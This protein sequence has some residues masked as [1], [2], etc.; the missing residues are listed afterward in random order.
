MEPQIQY[1]K[2]SDGVNIAYTVFGAGDPLVVAPFIPGAAFQFEARIEPWRQWEAALSRRRT[3]IRYDC[4]GSGLSDHGVTDRSLGAM[5][6]DLEAVADSLRL[7]RF[8][9]FGWFFSGPS[10]IAYAA[11]HPARVSHLILWGRRSECCANRTG[12]RIPKPL[13]IRCSA[14]ITPRL[15]DNGLAVFESVSMRTLREVRWFTLLSMTPPRF[16][17]RC[18]PPSLSCTRSVWLYHRWRR[19]ARWPRRSRTPALPSS[20]EPR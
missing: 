17:R 4:R 18:R 16:S 1:A 7:D 6:G 14:G 13:R 9:L 5:V 12:K 3:I 20:T 2:T 10:A 8:A 15:H 19:H 11:K